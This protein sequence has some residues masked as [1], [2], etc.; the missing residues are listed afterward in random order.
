M[1]VANVRFRL[2]DG[3]D[4]GPTSFPLSTTVLAVKE[5]V[6]RDWPVARGTAALAACAATAVA[7]RQPPPCSSRMADAARVRARRRA[8]RVQEREAP[9]GPEALK[10]ILAGR[11]LDN[12]LTLADARTP[13]DCLVTMHLVVAPAK[14]VRGTCDGLC[15]LAAGAALNA[16]RWRH[17]TAGGQGQGQGG[18]GGGAWCTTAQLV[19][20]LRRAVSAYLEPTH[21]YAPV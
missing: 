21:T 4:L 18:D 14:P 3:V 19:R 17:R 20:L 12:G 2:L 11:M 9:A 5:A 10:V 1:A 13:T 7:G 6:L 16:P 15:A 8:F